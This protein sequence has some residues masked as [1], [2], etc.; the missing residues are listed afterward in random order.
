MPIFRSKP[1][2]VEAMF[3]DGENDDEILDWVHENNGGAYV[4]GISKQL[5]VLAKEGW[6]AVPL[7]CMI[8]KSPQGGFYPCNMETFKE[9]YEEVKS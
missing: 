3:S 6:V 5:H 2:E 1:I 4:D 7:D 9:R 8:I